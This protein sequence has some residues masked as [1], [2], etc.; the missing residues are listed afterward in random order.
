MAEFQDENEDYGGLGELPADLGYQ[1]AQAYS[2]PTAPG[3]DVQNISPAAFNKLPTTPVDY[4]FGVKSVF[5]SRPING[6]DFTVESMSKPVLGVVPDLSTVSF[7]APVGYIAILRLF[8]YQTFGY[9]SASGSITPI[10]NAGFP[11]GAVATNFIFYRVAIDGAT[12]PGFEYANS[13]PAES[14][15]LPRYV[16]ANGK[17]QAFVV[18]PENKTLTITMFDKDPNTGLGPSIFM[19]HMK[20]YGNVIPSLGIPANIA[21]GSLKGQ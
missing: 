3:G 7:T 13:N 14:D 15:P 17:I 9:D 8:E 20:I 2:M 16:D 21:V 18:I 4:G 5:D 10:V 6:Y 1:N 12:V 19:R 11:V